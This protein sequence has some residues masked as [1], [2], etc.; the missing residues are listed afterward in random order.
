MRS[1]VRKRQQK[2]RTIISA[3]PCQLVLALVDDVE[4]TEFVTT[5]VVERVPVDVH[6]DT[7]EP[8]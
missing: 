1:T 6:R 2:D 8:V 4:P 7:K 3:T 5:S